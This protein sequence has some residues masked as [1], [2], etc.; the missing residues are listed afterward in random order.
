MTFVSVHLGLRCFLSRLKRIELFITIFQLYS[1]INGA[2]DKMNTGHQITMYQDK[3]GPLSL[4]RH[5]LFSES[6]AFMK[7]QKKTS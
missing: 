5:T 4:N 6:F 3:K 2:K 7:S 1:F